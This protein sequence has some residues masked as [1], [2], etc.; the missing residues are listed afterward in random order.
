MT[1][2]R[3]GGEY[4]VALLDL[5]ACICGFG[6]VAW[7]ESAW[8]GPNLVPAQEVWVSPWIICTVIAWLVMVF[9]ESQWNDGV[10]L[11]IDGYLAVIGANLVL[12]CGLSWMF[13]LPPASWLV[14]FGGSA[15]SIAFSAV[16]RKWVSNRRRPGSK[17][18]LLVGF[19]DHTASL[20]AVLKKEDIVGGL[21]DPLTAPPP[22]VAFLG[23]ADR[24][25]E[26][27]HDRHPGSIVLSGQPTGLSFRQLLQLHYSGIDV[28][29]APD[30][31]ERA[32]RRVTW[33]YQRPSDMLFSLNPNTS[34]GML[35]FQ[36]VYKNLIGLAL[37]LIFA[38][39][40]ILTSLLIVMFTGGPALEHIECL[41]FRRT[42][43]QM[44]RFRTLGA[45]GELTRIGR[46]IVRFHLT[47]LPQLMNV[48]RGEMTLFG[49]APVRV[50]FAE[51]LSQLLPA[52]VYRFTVKPGI[53][54]WMDANPD[55]TGSLP[56][57]MLRLE[58]DLYY[59][60]Q[61]SPS[62]DVDILQ[63]MLFGRTPAKHQSPPVADAVRNS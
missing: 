24:L 57:E 52:Y 11:W 37:R 1:A 6:G 21:G 43:F 33:Q 26:V 8:F 39:L 23:T 48:V 41:G 31:Y 44:L 61:E 10:R 17:G 63:R 16:L 27:C 25:N 38:P 56:D 4:W 60:R 15:L 32:L 49:P 46:L 53:F 59:I 55:E 14:I 40:L 50:V 28:E 34:K 58:Y 2:H 13:D 62:L 47:N 20:A 5:L 42:P 3:R 29:G 7:A 19:D 30:L 45:D 36:A 9:P 35:A 22:Q 54:G 12:Q 51:R 18:L